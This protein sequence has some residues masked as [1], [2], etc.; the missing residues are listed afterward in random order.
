MNTTASPMPRTSR[1]TLVVNAQTSKHTTTIRLA[2]LTPPPMPVL[3][4][5]RTIVQLLAQAPPEL[6]LPGQELRAQAQPVRAP[7]GLAMTVISATTAMS[8]ARPRELRRV[9]L[10]TL[11]M[12]LEA[13]RQTLLRPREQRRV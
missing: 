13:R 11:Q 7:Q 6:A 9:T 1:A 2:P 8:A 4:M 12:M 3:V 10:I 5:P